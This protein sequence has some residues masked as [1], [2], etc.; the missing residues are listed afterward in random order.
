MRCHE[1][2]ENAVHRDPRL[3]NTLLLLLSDETKK[4]CK[5]PHWTNQQTKNP[6]TI[7]YLIRAVPNN[8]RCYYSSV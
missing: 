2:V 8:F 6:I 3:I 7:K 1:A 4:G 5:F